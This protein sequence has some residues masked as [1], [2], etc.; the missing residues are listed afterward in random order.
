MVGGLV[1]AVIAIIMAFS[2]NAV[3]G[4]VLAVALPIYLFLPVGIG[5]I[6]GC[7]LGWVVCLVLRKK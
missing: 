7:L 5:A 3:T 4:A 6:A 2:K 1:W